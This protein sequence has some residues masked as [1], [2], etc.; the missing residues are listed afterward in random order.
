MF[1]N[2]ELVFL[3]WLRMGPVLKN[4]YLQLFSGR[5]FFVVACLLFK[6][7]HVRADLL[8]SRVAT[9][10]CVAGVHSFIPLWH[11]FFLD[12]LA[13]RTVHRLR[14]MRLSFEF[15]LQ[16]SS[17]HILIYS[18]QASILCIASIGLFPSWA[19]LFAI[20]GNWTEVSQVSDPV[21]VLYRTLKV[22][23]IWHSEQVNIVLNVHKNHKTY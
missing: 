17:F 13:H 18:S 23:K 19:N 20:K 15:D 16:L 10:L 1:H 22:A 2:L 11:F 5:M 3:F 21:C 8:L 14:W 7:D 12:S 4:C 9:H 6:T